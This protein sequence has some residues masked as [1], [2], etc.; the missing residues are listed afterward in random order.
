MNNINSTER[1]K[2][3]R[4]GVL[5]A[6]RKKNID[7]FEEAFKNKL[8]DQNFQFA[9]AN[10]DDAYQLF[11]DKIEAG[12]VRYSSDLIHAK[13]TYYTSGLISKE[14]FGQLIQALAKSMPHTTIWMSFLHYK[15]VGAVKYDLNSLFN[16]VFCLLDFDGDTVWGFSTDN[17]NTA[18][19]SIDYTEGAYGGYEFSIWGP[20]ADVCKHFLKETS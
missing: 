15:W 5:M 18:C 9:Y 16:N 19:I 1:M 8:A 13:E 11:E 2:K 14:E 10:L 3:V 6:Y 20:W 4:F 7:S 12:I 17:T